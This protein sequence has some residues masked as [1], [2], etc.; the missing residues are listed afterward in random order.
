M[1]CWLST[2]SELV[3]LRCCDFH[4]EDT[5]MRVFIERSKTDIYRDGAWV[6]IAKTVKSTCPVTLTLRYFE[7]GYITPDSNEFL[8]RPLKFLSKTGVYKFHDLSQLSYTRAREIALSTFDSIG[9][10][11]S[12][13]RLRMLILATVYLR[14]MGVGDLKKLKM[15][16]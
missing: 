4:F 11:T 6:V 1:L 15:A 16:M 13:L 7:T 3:N 5:F 12:S 14:G 9:L 10:R 2:F 8:F